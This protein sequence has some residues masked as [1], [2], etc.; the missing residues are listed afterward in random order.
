MSLGSTIYQL[1]TQ[2]GLSQNALAEA[3]EV[4]R[5]S[6]SKWETDASVPELDKLLRLSELFG[7]TL[8]ELVRGEAAPQPP[9]SP[10]IASSAVPD[11]PSRRKN[12]TGILLCSAGALILLV[13][14]VTGL[15]IPGLLV[16]IPLMLC[17]V[18]CLLFK[19]P[20]LWCGWTIYL[21]ADFCLRIF[22]GLSWSRRLLFSFADGASLSALIAWGLFLLMIVLVIATM[23]RFLRKPIHSTP[24]NRLLLILG[25]CLLLPFLWA[26]HRF[27]LSFVPRAAGVAEPFL[28]LSLL[29]LIITTCRMVRSRQTS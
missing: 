11:T 27:T 13:C 10:P 2:R 23:L 29:F 21:A 25:W 7:V 6:I 14:S 24:A 20:A 26:L 9:L 8:D 18:V 1:R 22:T 19:N 5:Q 16:A 15:V 17:G 4:S 28:L 3:L 12:T